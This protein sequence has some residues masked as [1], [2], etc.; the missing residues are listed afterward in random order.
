MKT[1]QSK[2]KLITAL[3]AA[4]MVLCLALGIS[5]LMPKTQSAYA[6]TYVNADG[7]TATVDADVVTSITESS[8]TWN[9]GWYI[10]EAT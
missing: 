2:R 3:L 10:V 5:L 8:T 9:A 6:A 7:Q 4:L 1:T